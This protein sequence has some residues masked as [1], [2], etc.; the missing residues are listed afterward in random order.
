M[1]IVPPEYNSV[2]PNYYAMSKSDLIEVIETQQSVIHDLQWHDEI[3]SPNYYAMSKSDLIEVIETQQSVI[4]D[5]QW[6]DEIMSNTDLPIAA[7]FA[8][9]AI[10]KFTQT[11][12]PC[13][14]GYYKGYLPEMEKLAGVSASTISRGIQT[15]SDATDAIDKHTD[16]IRDERGRLEKNL[17][18]FRKNELFEAASEIAPI[19]EVAKHGGNRRLPCPECGCVHRRRKTVEECAACSHKFYENE[20]IILGD[21][22]QEESESLQLATLTV[23][24]LVSDCNMPLPAHLELQALPQWVV[25][26]Y[27]APEKPRADGKLTKVPYNARPAR[28]P[29]KAD[30]TNPATWTTYEQARATF[31]DSQHWRRPYTGVG[32]CFK[33]GGGIVGIDQDGSLDPRIHSYTERSVSGDGIHTYARGSLPRN[34][35]RPGIELY[36]HARY[37]CWTG[38]HL[39]GTPETIEDGQAELDAL[40]QELVPDV[41]VIPN[42]T[43]ASHFTCSRSDDE[44]LMKARNAPNGAKFRRLYDDGNWSG[45]ASQSEADAALCKMLAYWGEGDVSTIERLFEHSGLMREKWNRADYR[46]RTI[47]R[48]LGLQQRRAS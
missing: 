22:E 29:Q 39:A 9:R 21:E 47:N 46:E 16:E 43:P 45:Y 19:K 8:A 48:A 33:A 1:T 5:L 14:D 26:R 10:R 38:Q 25:W 41:Q 34:I 15:L 23:D 3:M 7:R 20:R 4:H 31:E 6:H 18:Y 2:N 44:I 27:E 28:S 13:D 36:D 35:K 24:T 30:S 11:R 32:F 12:E 37:F 40:Y 17:L 42:A